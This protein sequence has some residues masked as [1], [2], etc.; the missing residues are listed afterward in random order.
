VSGTNSISD[1]GVLVPAFH[2]TKK[3]HDMARYLFAF[4]LLA[5]SAIAQEL[6]KDFVRDNFEKSKVVYE[7]AMTKA[8]A[9][10]LEALDSKIRE[11]AGTGNLEAVKGLQAEKK[12]YEKDGKL[13]TAA[14]MKK[15]TSDFQAAVDK[16][17]KRMMPPMFKVKPVLR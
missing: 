5:S 9:D 3:V 2:L 4:L 1:V 6:E 17:R 15:G 11:I 7:D 10:Y 14:A 16:A 12:E 13:A 8:K